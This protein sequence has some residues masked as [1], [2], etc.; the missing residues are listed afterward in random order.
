MASINRYFFRVNKNY[1]VLAENSREDVKMSVALN[2]QLSVFGKFTIAPLP[3]VITDLMNKINAETQETFLPNIIN[4]QQIEIPSNRIIT[5]ANLGFVTQNQQ[6][7]I[8]ILNNRI[9]VNY[10]KTVDS[11]VD[12][13]T[14]YAFSAKAL[15]AIMDYFGIV[16]NRLAVN[17][18]QVCEFD[19]F[20]KMHLCGKKLVTS[21]AYYDD[22]EFS[23]WSMRTNSQ[24]DIELDERQE[25]LNVITDISSGQDITGQKAAC[26]FHIDINTA[27]QNQSMRFRKDSLPPFVQNAKAIAIKLIEDVERLIINDK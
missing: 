22:K 5:T 18:Q 1:Y 13:E 8:A 12:I 10:N 23:E 9:D 15:V 20:E 26:L 21:A 2:Y 6:Y 19:S 14:F 4:S 11:D 24:V 7:S 17:I 16:S 3:D 25:V 27:P